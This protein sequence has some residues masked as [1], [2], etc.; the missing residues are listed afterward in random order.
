MVFLQ[1]SL[2]L[3]SVVSVYFVFFFDFFF[4]QLN[5]DVCAQHTRQSISVGETINYKQENQ[6]TI[7]ITC[8]K[9]HI[10]ALR[11]NKQLSSICLMWRRAHLKKCIIP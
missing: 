1:V 6:I 4:N 8:E 9:R 2:S 3:E 10:N 7:Y 11:T 5:V